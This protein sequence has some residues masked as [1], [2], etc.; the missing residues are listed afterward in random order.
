MD[1]APGMSVRLKLTLSY[2]GFLMLAAALLLA[3]VWVFLLRYVPDRAITTAA[4]LAP[5]RSILLR[6]FAP[7]AAI[8]LV[9]LLVFGLLGGWLLAGRMLAPV[10]LSRLTATSAALFLAAGLTACSSDE[11]STDDPTTPA[12]SEQSSASMPAT[13]ETAPA[14]QPKAPEGMERP[15]AED[16]YEKLPA[17]DSFEVTSTDVTDGEQI[18]NKFVFEGAE[19]DAQ[20]VS[21]Q[22]SWSGFP[23]ETK[24][25]VVTVFDPDVPRPSR[26]WHW[27]VVDIPADV[28]SLD[29]GAGAEA[30]SPT[31]RSSCARITAPRLTA[32]RTRRRATGRT[33]TTSWCTPWTW[34]RWV[35]T[36]MRLTRSCRST[37]RR[38]RWLARSWCPPSCTESTSLA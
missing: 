29:T 11:E 23:E 32:V 35:S 30:S 6:A 19:E 22:L 13:S 8:V 34:T 14:E 33:A 9:F 17:V 36:R 24:S 18:D 15:L 12:G 38:T 7:A 1:R 5:N 16:P 3:A 21:P 4:G 26:F 37:L 2:A 31:A 10:R 27:S 25:F 28:T 20:N